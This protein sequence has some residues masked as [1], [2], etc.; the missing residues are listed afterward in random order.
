MVQKWIFFFLYRI[1]QNLHFT[2]EYEEFFISLRISILIDWKLYFRN[3]AILMQSIQNSTYS[4]SNFDISMWHSVVSGFI[5]NPIKPRQAIK[6]L[7]PFW[8]FLIFMV[9]IYIKRG[10]QNELFLQ[11]QEVV[12]KM[13]KYSP[14]YGTTVSYWPHISTVFLKVATKRKK[15]KNKIT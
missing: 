13:S 14:N 10:P 12:L 11:F 5:T 4:N 6:R 7:W 1:D 8:I 2:N 3:L 9:I 15:M